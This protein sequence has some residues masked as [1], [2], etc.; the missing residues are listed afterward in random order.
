MLMLNTIAKEQT[1]TLQAEEYML[2]KVDFPPP[3]TS[4]DDIYYW[5]SMNS[6]YQLEVGLAAETG[7]LNTITLVLIPPDWKLH[8][9]SIKG[10][11]EMENGKHG[12]PVFRLD[13]WKDRIGQKE[14]GADRA[15]RSYDEHVSFKLH[16][17]P[18]GV[19]ILFDNFVPSYMVI[20]KELHFLFNAGDEWCGLIAKR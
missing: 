20:N 10:L 17:A 8:R 1:F 9:T 7:T 14:T 2:F 15:L 12:L 3:L 13:P 11:C 4:V 19:A 18:D 5:R 6:R 16:I